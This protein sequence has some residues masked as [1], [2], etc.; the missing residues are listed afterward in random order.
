[1]KHYAVQKLK[2][3]YGSTQK[4]LCSK[5]LMFFRRFHGY[6]LDFKHL[7]AV[8]VAETSQLNKERGCP[9]TFLYLIR[10]REQLSAGDK[11]ADVVESML[12]KTWSVEADF[13]WKVDV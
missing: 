13:I 11:W 7:L 3:S 12:L 2:K 9:L 10:S 8:G 1:M 6:V 5:F 4:T